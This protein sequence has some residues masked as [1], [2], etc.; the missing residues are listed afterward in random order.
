MNILIQ[1]IHQDLKSLAKENS[2]L[3]SYDDK[4]LLEEQAKSIFYMPKDAIFSNGRAQQ[5]PQVSI[6]Y[7]PLHAEKG[8]KYHNDVED[9]AA[10]QFPALKARIY[11]NLGM[12]N[13]KLEALVKETVLKRCRALQTKMG[14]LRIGAYVKFPD[15]E[16]FLKYTGQ[17]LGL[18]FYALSDDI[19]SAVPSE[20]FRLYARNGDSYRLLL[21]LP[22]LQRK[23]YRCVGEGDTLR[24]YVTG[25]YDPATQDGDPVLVVDLSRLAKAYAEPD[26]AANRSQPI[27]PETNRTSS[28]TGSGR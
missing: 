12:G 24:V 28:P 23:G 21:S 2:W 16:G 6:G 4:C 5:P 17:H 1:E 25:M 26:G 13:E 10:A 3:S 19:G 8:F 20:D 15:A 7:L 27:R 22:R 11:V 18:T 14:D 9:E